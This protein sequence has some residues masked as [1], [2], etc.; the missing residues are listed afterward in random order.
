MP[1]TGRLADMEMEASS[2]LPTEH[3]MRSTAEVRLFDDFAK[4]KLKVYSHV[5]SSRERH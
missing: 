1:G 5:S 2:L 4:A 3:R